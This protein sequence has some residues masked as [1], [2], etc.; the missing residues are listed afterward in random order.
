M[1]SFRVVAAPER[2]ER[3][4]I[5]A[6]KVNGQV[7][8]DSSYEGTFHTHVRALRSAVGDHVVVLEDDAILCGD[9]VDHVEQLIAERPE[10]LIGLYV[11]RSHPQRIQ[12]LLSELT[13]TVGW[14]DAPQLT[15][16]LWWAVGYVMPAADIPT[17]LERLASR[18]QHAWIETDRRIGAWHAERG[19]LSYP[20]PS[21]IDHDDLLPSTTSRGRS[22]RVAW[23]HCEGNTCG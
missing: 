20:L 7:I 1:I 3:A 14:L 13:Q 16:Q 22:A 8:L 2:L 5:L 12:P 17:V 9:F 4:Q 18:P 15:K 21:P 23:A 10:H 6:D 19:R 11:G